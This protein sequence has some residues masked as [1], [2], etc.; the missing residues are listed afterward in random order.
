MTGLRFAIRGVIAALGPMI[1]VFAAFEFAAWAAG[2]LDLGG[3]LKRLVGITDDAADAAR[4]AD[5]AYEGLNDTFTQ[6][7]VAAAMRGLAQAQTEVATA[8]R[9]LTDLERERAELAA[10]LGTA[11]G[12]QGR[13]ARQRIRAMD[14]EIAAQRQVVAAAKD[15]VIVAGQ[16]VK[17]EQAAARAAT[18]Y[19]DA[20]AEVRKELPES[21]PRE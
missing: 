5:A 3:K 14:D 11:G 12:H 19:A 13:Q 7:E 18:D 16:E 8:T 17:A 10:R 15:H 20:L 9:A 4:D 6:T 21:P 1:L 2:A